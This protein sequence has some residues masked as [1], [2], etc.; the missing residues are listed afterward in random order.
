MTVR[1][2]RGISAS[3]G[4]WGSTDVY[5]KGE[6]FVARDGFLSVLDEDNAGGRPLAIYAPGEW[7]IATKD[8]VAK[9]DSK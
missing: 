2:V 9:Y 3:T 4:R 5:E 6:A 8:G 1:V 7:R